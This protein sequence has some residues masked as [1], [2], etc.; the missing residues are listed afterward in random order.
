MKIMKKL[1]TL[2][3]AV[4]LVVPCVATTARAADG[5]I[6]LTDHYSV[7]T[8][9]TLEVTCAVKTSA[10]QVG[11][12]KVDMSYDT[13]II[14]FKSGA[15]VTETTPG[16]L[17]LEG[18]GTSGAYRVTLAFDVLK[19]GETKLKVTDYQATLSNGEALNCD[20]GYAEIKVT[21][22]EDLVDTPTEPTATVTTDKAV[23]VNGTEYILSGEF[24][25]SAIPTGFVEATMDYEGASYKVAQHEVN[26]MYLGYLVNASQEGKF[27]VFNQ[28]DATFSP[29]VQV[30]ISDT[31]S[32]I[33]LSKVDNVAVPDGYQV[34]SVTFNGELFPAWQ[35][36]DRVEYCL[37]YAMNNEG[38]A[39]LYQYDSIEGTYQRYEVEEK[40]PEE[41]QKTANTW[42]EKLR[43]FMEENLDYVILI[44]GLGFVFFLLIIIVLS[45]KLYNRN[46]ELDELY[47]EYDIDVEEEV[48]EEKP[49]KK[50]FFK[51][52]KV[53]DEEEF[54][55]FEDEDDIDLDDEYETEMEDELLEDAEE[56]ME[57]PLE[58]PEEPIHV[59]VEEEPAG[60]LSQVQNS[61]FEDFDLDFI[62]LDD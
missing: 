10:G 11:K 1:A 45:V 48:V 52:A 19:K 60:Q 29:Y 50:G 44:A 41:E 34:S 18:T 13:S 46:A 28:E 59:D 27:F 35:S 26:G 49:E 58:E 2:L 42:Y 5:V 17:T 40:Q 20:K 21:K 4:C 23:T 3:L 32:I 24:E 9:Q 14:K 51:N 47:D 43:N 16:S 6:Q 39:S 7:T 57:I 61:S 54:E 12:V 37:L 33:L 8:G 55:D 22:G 15:G 62:D 56:E 31:A 30:S 36:V 38:N 25:A 53:Q